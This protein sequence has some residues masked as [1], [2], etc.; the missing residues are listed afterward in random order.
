MHKTENGRVVEKVFAY[1]AS[2]V[3]SDLSTEDGRPAMNVNLVTVITN[4]SKLTICGELCESLRY[5]DSSRQT[6]I[7]CSAVT[8]AMNCLNIVK[9]VQVRVFW[10]LIDLIVG[11]VLDNKQHQSKQVCMK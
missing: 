4:C 2:V 8:L 7:T 10:V 3:E 9:I 6:C 11:Q 1:G 5:T